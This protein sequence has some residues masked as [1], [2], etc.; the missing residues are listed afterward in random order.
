MIKGCIFD[1]D[2]TLVDSLQDLASSTNEVLNKRGYPIHDITVYNYFVGN[3]VRKLVERAL[4][5]DKKN[6]TDECLKEFYE[7]YERRC[8]EYTYCYD[9]I[10]ELLKFLKDND[11]K[12]AVVTN[13]PHHLAVK[14]C[15][16]YFKDMFID[17]I[18]NN[19]EFPLKPDPM[20]TLY[21]LNKF[22]V[23][24]DQCAF[25]GD[26]NVDIYTGLNAKMMTI[27][28]TWGFRTYEELKTAGA[29]YVVTKPHEIKE[30]IDEN[31]N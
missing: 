24:L 10:N 19:D 21:V 18:G 30:I 6:E 23:S 4:P 27:G 13:K 25:I 3:G 20:S 31:R 16:H 28:V 29:T 2:G 12:L 17:V 15:N 9:G 14:I 5:Q 11:I 8:L 7:V 22:N 1:L 26:S